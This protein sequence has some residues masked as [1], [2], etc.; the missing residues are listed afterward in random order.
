MLPSLVSW[1][2]KT[3]LKQDHFFPLNKAGIE[4]LLSR[5]RNRE[6]FFIQLNTLIFKVSSSSS[7]NDLLKLKCMIGLI[8]LEEGYYAMVLWLS[9]RSYLL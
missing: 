9:E 8:C 1:T 3:Y 7:Y 2:E 5:N 4:S 6:I